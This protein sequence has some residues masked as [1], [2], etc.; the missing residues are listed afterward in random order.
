MKIDLERTASDRIV[1]GR[2]NKKKKRYARRFNW[3][4]IGEEKK[5][6]FP[7][8]DRPSG[9]ARYWSGLRRIRLVFRRIN[10]LFVR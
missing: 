1:G 8:D 9:A 4:S 10:Y 3:E 6:G 7:V 2:R 5:K